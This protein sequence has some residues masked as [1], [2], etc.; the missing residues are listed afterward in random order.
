MVLAQKH[1]PQWSFQVFDTHLTAG[2]AAS[3]FVVASKI[4]MNTENQKTS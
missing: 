4:K 3:H 2:V 1:K